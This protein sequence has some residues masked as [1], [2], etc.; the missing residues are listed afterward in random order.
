MPEGGLQ[1]LR[2]IDPRLDAATRPT[3]QAMAVSSWGSAGQTATLGVI[4]ACVAA[5]SQPI[6]AKLADYYSRTFV[7]IWSTFIFAV[8]TIV[9]A[10][11]TGFGPYIGGFVLY[12]LGFGAEH[13]RLHPIERAHNSPVHRPA[14]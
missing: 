1:P 9:Q 14:L 10:T 8:G 7:L 11:A 2:E 5:I 3:Y 6:H 12:T 4:R 13:S